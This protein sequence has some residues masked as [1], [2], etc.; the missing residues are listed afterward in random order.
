MKTMTCRDLRGPC[1]L[2]HHGETADDVINAQDRHLREAEKSG[3]ATHQ[4][5]P[6]RHEGS[7]AA[8]QEVD[9]L[10]PRHQAGLRRPPRRL[11]LL[12][13]GL[14]SA[15]VRGR[16]NRR[17]AGGPLG[18]D[19]GTPECVEAAGCRLRDRA[20]AASHRRT[21]AGPRG[22]GRAQPGR[23]GPPRAPGP[24]RCSPPSSAKNGSASM[25]CICT[26]TPAG[27]GPKAHSP[28]MG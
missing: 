28:E 16:G 14:T 20:R 7:L 27:H 1:D 4:G 12:S 2:E 9:G 21:G 22:R 15:T 25:P 11:T 26:G 5:G 19:P 3:D 24:R 8:P 6:R 17:V 23:G 13:L 18:R 10:V